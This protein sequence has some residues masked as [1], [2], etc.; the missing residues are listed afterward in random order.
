MVARRANRR[1]LLFLF[2]GV[3]LAAQFGNVRKITVRSN[4]RIPSGG[5]L[6]MFVLVGMLVDVLNV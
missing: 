4:R 5:L 3:T 6:V 2:D 1:M